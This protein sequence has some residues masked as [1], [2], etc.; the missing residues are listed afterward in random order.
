M[1]TLRIDKL[2]RIYCTMRIGKFGTDLSYLE[3]VFREILSLGK[4]EVKKKSFQ[5]MIGE[6]INVC[7][8]NNEDRWIIE[9]LEHFELTE[10]YDKKLSK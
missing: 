5:K 4:D 7:H 1:K 2:T 10:V 3:E 9:V 6:F 8:S